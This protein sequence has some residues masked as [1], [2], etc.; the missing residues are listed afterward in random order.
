MK[1]KLNYILIFKTF[2]LLG[3]YFFGNSSVFLIHT[4]EHAES[5][6][7]CHSHEDTEKTS[8]DLSFDETCHHSHLSETL[9][10]CILCNNIIVLPHV[11]SSSYNNNLS[12]VISQEF[13]NVK[14]NYFRNSIYNLLNRGPP[15]LV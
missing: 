8:C 14:F 12:H 4:H 9:E 5:H 3:I 2:F 6:N 15:L 13:L 10:E 7:H 11:Y 1:L